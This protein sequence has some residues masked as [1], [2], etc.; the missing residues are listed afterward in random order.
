[1][2]DHGGDSAQ[3]NDD[4]IHAEQPHDGASVTLF[5]WVTQSRD[6]MRT[7]YTIKTATLASSARETAKGVM[8]MLLV[9]V[10]VVMMMMVIIL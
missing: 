5:Y 2:T 7:S 1:M 3:N 8:I 10:V 6:S 9:V 4:T